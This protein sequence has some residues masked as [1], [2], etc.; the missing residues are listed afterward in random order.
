MDR[1]SSA[2]YDCKNHILHKQAYIGMAKAIAS[3]TKAFYD[4][5]KANK[6]IMK[7]NAFLQSDPTKTVENDS[8]KLFAILTMGEVGRIYYG[9]F[10]NTNIE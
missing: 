1:L 9:A 10:K 5:E 2:A 8:I 7:L 4:L 6:L 3:V